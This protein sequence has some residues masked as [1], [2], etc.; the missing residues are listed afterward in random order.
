MT[1]RPLAALILAAGQGS[2]MKSALPKVLHPVAHRAM[3]AHVH[4][5]VSRLS[6]ARTIVVVAPGMAA[7]MPPLPG[8][9]FAVQREPLG[10]G[11]AVRAAAPALQDFAGDVLVLFGDTPLVTADTLASLL[12]ALGQT[13]A[14]AIVLAG[15]RLAEPGGYARLVIAA[16]GMLDAAVEARDC[17]EAERDIRF[18]NAGPLAA[19]ARTLLSL[20]DGI[21]RDN[22][23]GE[24]YLTAAVAA[25]RARGLACRAVEVP[26]E[27]MAGVNDRLELAAVEAA[28]QRRLRRRLMRDGVGMIAPDTVYLAADTRIGPDTTI[29]PY[30][31]FGPGVTIGRQVEI[32]GFCHIAGAVIGDRA[33]VG[34]YA[35]LRP[36]ADLAEEVHI[37]NFVEVKNARLGAGAKANHLAYLG[38]AAIGARANIGAGTITCNYDGIEKHRTE[39]GADVF[40]GTNSSLVA[41]V[42][43]ADGAIVA[44][45]SVITDDVPADALAVA[46]GRQATKPGRAAE[47]RRKHAAGRKTERT[48]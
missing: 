43:I 17:G 4:D 20:L 38:D 12:G 14:P 29:G 36:G 1:N 16:D 3:I 47:W 34:P 9:E 21:G 23:Q 39:I 40:I 18:L 24:Y 2:R 15:M 28:M 6:P 42:T 35:R 33:R 46:R 10:T 19:D 22:A 48:G 27:E 41:P 30:V 44:A 25:A 32:V 7:G 26:A 45:G 13:P 31:V 11:D 37:G 5:A 8:V